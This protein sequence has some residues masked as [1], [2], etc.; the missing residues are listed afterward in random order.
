[1]HLAHKALLGL[2]SASAPFSKRRSER[3]RRSA[4][5]RDP[6]R[7][8]ADLT[9]EVVDATF[10]AA[11]IKGES[12]QDSARARRILVADYRLPRPDRSAGERATFGLVCDLRALGFEVTFLPT[13]ME[14]VS[15]YREA[16]EA[17]GVTVITRD[18]GV[19]YGGDYIRT[20]GA[21]FGAFY[22][23]RLDVAEALLPSARAVAPDARVIFHAPDL[24]FLREG[25]AAELVGK[26]GDVE[27]VARTKARE[28]AIMRVCDHVV[29][30][31][32]AEIPFV[33]DIVPRSKISVFPAL[34][35]PV[36]KS[37]AGY[38]ARRDIFFLGGFKHP[39][40]IDSVKWFADTVWPLV[41]A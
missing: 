4:E 21:K 37:P 11:R 31:S 26:L 32:P 5:K 34:Y 14:N 9:P 39:P 28:A 19:T 25:R 1:M 40:N 12:V 8:R 15:P 17:I 41:H 18:G 27:A 20:E 13:D 24:Y 22:F 6:H 16:L 23:I 7:F 10:R 30:V 2:A 38:G 29:L 35:S 33:S 36:A 3:F